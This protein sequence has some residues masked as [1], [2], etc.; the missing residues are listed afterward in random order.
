MTP[1]V[2]LKREST[3]NSE[4]IS[5]LTPPEKVTWQWNIDQWKMY[6]LLNMGIFQCHVRFQGCRCIQVPW[7]AIKVEES[8]SSFNLVARLPFYL[9]R[10]L[11]LNWNVSKECAFQICS[12]GA[13]FGRDSRDATWLFRK[14]EEIPK[15]RDLKILKNITWTSQNVGCVEDLRLFSWGS[16][17]MEAF[18][19]FCHREN[20]GGFLG[21]GPLI[22]N[23]IDTPYN[24][25]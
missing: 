17:E 3:G 14:R 1:W 18:W 6:F 23:P 20:G 19:Y 8:F 11:Q 10:T 9:P 7:W 5:K 4:V 25:L 13:L 22:I 16:L 12:R 15:W 24:I 21:W 2:L